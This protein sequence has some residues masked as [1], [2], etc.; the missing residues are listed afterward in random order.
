MDKPLTQEELEEY[1]KIKDSQFGA[2][3]EQAAVLCLE[4]YKAYRENLNVL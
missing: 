4:Y 3:E 2:A 1:N